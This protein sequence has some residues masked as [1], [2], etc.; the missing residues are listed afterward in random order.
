MFQISEK[1]WYLPLWLMLLGVVAF[2]QVAQ[3]PQTFCNPLNLNYMFFDDAL[4][5]RE[6]ADPVIVLF[7]DDY[8]LFASHSGGY[9]TSPDLRNW[10]F[11]IP[12]GLNIANYAPA[13][14]VM[15]DSLFFITSEGVQQVYKTGDPKSGKWISKPIA[16]GYQDPALFLDDDGRLY[17]YHGLSQENPIIY[18]VELDPNTFR[19]I[20]SQV[21]LFAGAGLYAT[22]GWER[23]GNGVVFESDMRPWI[24][25]SWMNKKNGK[26]YLKYSAPGTEWKTY[27][28]GVY[29]ADSPLGPF[30]YAP[31]SPVDFKPTG[32]VSGGGHGATFKDKDGNYWHVGTLTI[33]VKH[34][35][36]RRLALFPVGIDADGQI[37]TNTA[38]G[39]YPQYYPGVKANPVDENFAGMLLLSHKKFVQASSS[40]A[41]YGVEKAVDED[42]RTYWSALTADANEWLMIDLGKEC[43]VEAIQVNFAEHKT[44]PSIV[45]GRNNVLY[46]QYILEKSLDGINWD[47]LV[48]K[49]Q[50]LQDLPHDYLELAQASQARYIKLTNAALAPGMGLFAI[51]DLRVFGNSEQAVFTPATNVTVERDA[52]DGRDAVIRWTPVANADGYIV[53]YGI[54]PTKL[55]NNYIVY[56]VDSVFIRSL[57]HGVDYYFSVEA[58]DSGTEY[59]RPVGEIHSS[60]SGN[61]NDV[62]SWARYDGTTWVHP[63]PNV[64]VLSDGAITILDGHTITVTAADSADQL[65]VAAGGNLV[66]NKG[67]TQH[68]KNGVGTDLVVEGNV[69]NHGTIT[70]EEGATLSFVGSGIYAHE[71]DGG[72]IPTAIWRDSSFCVIDSV[73]TVAPVNANQNFFNIRWNCP[74]QTDNLNLRWNDVTIGGNLIIENTGSGRWQLCAPLAGESATVN[75]KGNIIQSGGQ[76]SSNGTGNAGTTII[77]NQLG[78]IKVTGGNFSVSRG[79][80][81]GTGTT[82]WNIEGSVSL[83]NATT[84]NSNAAG[85]KFVFT[86]NGNVQTLAFSSVTFG[87][88][89]FPVEV[90]DG[91]ILNLGLNILEGAGGF[92]LKAGATMQTAHVSGIDGSI[93]CT[94]TKTYSKAASYG[95]NGTAA[96]VTGNSMPDTVNG[97][98]IANKAGVTLSN[99]VVV[100][101]T[102]ELSDGALALGGKALKYGSAGSLKYSSSDAQTTS[103]AEFPAVS[104][105]GNLFV[106]NKKGVTLHASRTI[107]GVLD[108]AGKLKLG[109]NSL[110]ARSAINNSNTTFVVTSDGG[111]LKLNIVGSAQTFFPVGASFYSP[112]WIT[113]SGTDDIL[114]VCATVDEK[115]APGGGRVKVKWEIS[116]ETEG[117]GNYTIQFGWMTSS[118]TSNFRSD[119]MGCAQIF[120]LQD[121]TE[122]GSGDY[123]YQ[124]EGVPYSVSRGGITRLGPFAV[125]KFIYVSGITEQ[126]SNL[127]TAFNLCQNY[128]NP[129]NPVTAIDF[130]L[131]VES[132]VQLKVYDLTGR[133]VKSLVERQMPAGRYT[134]QFDARELS[135]GIYFYRIT[136]GDF[137]KSYKMILLK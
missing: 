135:S 15:R 75:L 4:D 113:N 55:Y 100:N 122:A 22:H 90:D 64:P 62:N 44:D 111:T 23:R 68:I 71:Q 59:Y 50:N 86:G 24:E 18:G 41:G 101:G 63:A 52:A 72:T 32:F 13:V 67:V 2:G 114:G 58:F 16:K 127:P 39:D 40:L 28:D 20:G 29:V 94:G 17:M 112:V 26:Y 76:F 35:F 130:S 12:T 117:G 73:K 123:A 5:G 121:T 42:I 85:A 38:F 81:G 116:E 93:A 88:G 132:Y 106:V 61:W 9:W 124:F 49:S 65:T 104:G 57:N 30:Q 60:Q 129:F 105:P 69:K 47:V 137:T 14:V 10:E 82:A 115:D 103:D 31:Y 37:H 80:Q 99:S 7:K 51:Q 48:D 6:A 43:T 54:A 91:A 53:R 3:S 77:I 136:A 97:L 133:E 83:A 19:E 89:G 70:S 118:E 34:I 119:R 96:Q 95:F 102:L 1:Y 74:D 126:S 134:T 84:Q 125:G 98:I 131:P 78:D 120:N 45:R 109:T 33:S 87:S 11:I 36:E 107:A 108:L 110:T 21:V 27:S 92:N 66:I 46:H 25:G 79:S 128:P 8:Y 56:D